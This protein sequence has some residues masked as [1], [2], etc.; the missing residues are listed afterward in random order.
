MEKLKLYPNERE[1]KSE[2][3]KSQEFF[4]LF[5]SRLKSI[6]HQQSHHLSEVKIMLLAVGV[7]VLQNVKEN[8]FRRPAW[9]DVV[10]WY[11]LLM[12]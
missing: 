11:G 12:M 3:T 9:E 4:F 1:K 5:L 7:G 2:T 10:L 6:L 8:N